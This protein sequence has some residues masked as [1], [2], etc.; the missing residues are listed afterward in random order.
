M[1]CKLRS[2]FFSVALLLIACGEEQRTVHEETEDKAQEQMRFGNDEDEQAA[3][4]IVRVGATADNVESKPT[5]LADLVLQNG[6]IYTVNADQPWASAVAVKDG[7]IIY[8]GNVVG[9]SRFI[10]DGTDVIDLNDQMVLP[11]LHDSH[12][13][14][15]SSQLKR[16]DGLVI[17]IH[18]TSKEAVAKITDYAIT[19]PDK[20]VIIGGLLG[21]D[22]ELPRDI[23]DQIDNT[24]PIII[25]EESGHAAWAN[26]AALDAAGITN[27]TPNPQGG[28]IVRDENGRATGFLIDT[29]RDPLRP[30]I[31]AARQDPTME[32]RL[33]AAR[34]VQKW[35][36]SFGITSIKELHGG[37]DHLDTYKTLMDAGELTIRVSQ[38]FTYRPRTPDE[39]KAFDEFLNAR[40][41]YRSDQLNPDF[42][43][44][45]M[46]G[47]P[48]TLYM[49]EN[50]PGNNNQPLIDPEKLKD[51]FIK[52]DAMG[53]SV[54]VHAHGDAAIR[55][56]LDAVEA[57][58]KANG[59]SGIVHQNAHSS[60]PHQDDL[61]RFAEMNVIAEISPHTWYPGQTH[62]WVKKVM[63][64]EL[65]HSTFPAR[66]FV[67]A[68]AVLATGSD[69]DSNTATV[70]PFPAMEALITRKDPHG[71]RPNE[72]Y[73]TIEGL[74]VSEVIAAYTTGGAHAARRSRDLGTIEVGKRADIAVLNQNLFEIPIED[75]SETKV[76]YTFL[77]GKLVYQASE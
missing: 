16:G 61:V 38:H 53:M 68:G 6:S 28:K 59:D 58:R 29:A 5:L 45:N 43:K 4:S 65:L 22:E 60:L 15:L 46:D 21:M 62:D 12:V 55:S 77:D 70:N 11:G 41:H 54:A 50:Y 51:L 8:V 3:D 74:S 39:E 71:E 35:F 32:D 63:P 17:E 48:G 36:N 37:K 49:L 69:W 27:D 40:H 25:G 72:R 34:Q 33:T 44:L 75:I 31:N 14:G 10:G 7:K 56:V 76:L 73:G 1:K 30:L 24:R 23:L 42:I 66:S 2:S 47:V 18:E 13:H 52:F 9:V 64:N 19:N 20:A 57:T 26:S 67:D